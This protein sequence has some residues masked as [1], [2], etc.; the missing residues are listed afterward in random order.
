[1]AYQVKGANARTDTTSNEWIFGTV[2]PG[3]VNNAGHYEII[4]VELVLGNQVICKAP[5]G[6]AYDKDDLVQLI[7]VPSYLSI[8]TPFTL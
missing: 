2:N 1:M 4:L 7:R 5:L 6:N 3:T 8:L